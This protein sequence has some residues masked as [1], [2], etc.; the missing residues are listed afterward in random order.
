MRPYIDAIEKLG[1]VAEA[2]YLPRI[3]TDFDGLILCGGVD[4]DP[5]RYGEEINGS[6]KIDYDRDAAEFALLKAYVEAGKP[7][8]GICRGHQLI[9]VFFGGSLY[10]D[11]PEAV[12]HKKQ[13]KQDSVHAVRALSDSI[14]QKLY[15]EHFFVNSAHH[16]AIKAL[17]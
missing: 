17:G 8:F 9:N 3:N 15:G 10:Q 11:I 13:E 6:E 1:A 7:V 16:Q 12:L 2:T 5:H 4:V 14:L